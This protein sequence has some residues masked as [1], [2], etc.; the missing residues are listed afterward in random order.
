MTE[1]LLCLLGCFEPLMKALVGHPEVVF[2]GHEVA[3]DGIEGLLGHPAVAYQLTSGLPGGFNHV[4]HQAADIK[5]S[6]PARAV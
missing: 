4:F 2:H 3:T 6:G 1:V 5:V